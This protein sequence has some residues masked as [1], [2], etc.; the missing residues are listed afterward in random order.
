ML[1]PL[2]ITLL[3]AS[4]A[5]SGPLVVSTAG[6]LAAPMRELL[7]AFR[8]HYPEVEPQRES[9]GSVEAA[10]KLAEFGRIPDVL[11]VADGT[12]IDELLVPRFTGWW[13]AFAS[14]AMVVAYTDASRGAD[15]ITPANW[16]DVLQRKGVRVGRSD[17]AQDPSGYRTLMVFQL[18][19]RF[20]HRPGLAAALLAHS[21]REYTRPKEVDLIALLET[22]NLDYA[23]FYRTVA[24]QGHF[25]WIDLPPEIDLSDPDRA[26]EYAQATVTI[27]RSRREAKGD[28]HL[29]GAP[30]VYGIT[31]P[32]AAAH[33]AAARAFL[34]FVLGPEG[35]RILDRYGFVLPN[36]PVVHGDST[37]A[38]VAMG[39]DD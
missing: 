39:G 6:S 16:M 7:A 37:A 11:G 5:P 20:Y 25:K 14:N 21:T 3:V 34:R 15:E 35:R 13:L 1:T 30:I 9:S 10:R 12:V 23:V 26:D 38:R 22:A 2:L 17:P 19:E 36:R 4:Q 24:R 31:I 29:A 33:P 8:R 27:P 32:S 28:I 18:A